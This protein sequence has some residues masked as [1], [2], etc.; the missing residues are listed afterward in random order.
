M[1][2]TEGFYVINIAGNAYDQCIHSELEMD[3]SALHSS[4]S[5]FCSHFNLCLRSMHYNYGK[6]D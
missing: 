5:I 1:K 4:D 6:Q 2:S 3:I